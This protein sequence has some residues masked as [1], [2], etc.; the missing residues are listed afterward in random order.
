MRV[1]RELELPARIVATGQSV[2]EANRAQAATRPRRRIAFFGNFG[3]QNLGNEYTLQAVVQNVRR[4]APDA[5]LFCI[6][7]DPEDAEARHRIPARSMSYRYSREFRA[8][9]ANDKSS[10]IVR[11]LRRALVRGPREL[12]ELYRAYRTLSG[13]SAVVMTG[14]GMLGDFGI[15]PLD[16][17]YEILKWSALAKL[18]GAKLVFLSVGAGPI[19]SPLSRWIVKCAASLADYRS[20]RDRFSK[21]YLKGIGFDS[22]R[23]PIY[24][25]LAFSLPPKARPPASR[26]ERPVVGLGLMDYYGTTGSPRRGEEAYRHYVEKMAA[27]ARW[28]LDHGYQI[29]LLIGDAAYD[30][31]CRDDL[32]QEVLRSGVPAD[33][34]H[35]VAVPLPSTDA[36][37]DQIAATDL[38]VTTRFH[39]VLLALMLGK[40]VVALSYHQKVASLMDAMG[41]GA[42]CHDVERADGARLIEQFAGMERDAVAIHRRVEEKT[43]A[44]RKALDDQ[45]DSLFG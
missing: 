43:V 10:G 36:L 30:R 18:R 33:E 9:T 26:G 20:Y 11:L 19:A 2:T 25:D 23:D 38:V 1:F 4:R 39:T 42:Y 44:C 32:L 21:A 34:R 6:C 22:G 41:L 28:L 29:N 13:V 40:P 5:D 24:P 15:G 16:L 27:F 31:R 14:T 12:I 3:T 8:R 7:T 35:I 37:I 17:H 45:Y